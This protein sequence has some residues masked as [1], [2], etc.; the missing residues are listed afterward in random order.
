MAPV[1]GRKPEKPSHYSLVRPYQAELDLG[2]ATPNGLN[3]VQ[4][5]GTE[6]DNWLDCSGKYSVCI[7]PEFSA[8]NVTAKIRVIFQDGNDITLGRMYS[9]EVPIKN[10]G[11]QDDIRTSGY[12]HGVAEVV[13]TFGAKKYKILLTEPPTNSGFLSVF[14]G[15]I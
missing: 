8:S 9:E 4:I 5:A 7:A 2:G 3:A 6:S 10:T 15:A 14:S 1:L 11:K 13:F 12:Y